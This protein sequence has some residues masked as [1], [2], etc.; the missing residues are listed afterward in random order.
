[1]K[2]ERVMFAQAF[3]VA[4]LETGMFGDGGSGRDG[5]QASVRKHVAVGKGCAMPLVVGQLRKT[6]GPGIRS[7]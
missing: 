2:G 6:N 5:S 7:R 4:Q 1:M 3:H